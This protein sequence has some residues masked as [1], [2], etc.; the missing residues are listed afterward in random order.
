MFGCAGSSLLFSSCS[1]QGLLSRC[2]VRAECSG[3]LVVKLGLYCVQTSLVATRG[4]RSGGSGLRT[5]GSEVVV[6]RA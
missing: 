6:Q 2:G 5:A 1:E 4:L 3:F